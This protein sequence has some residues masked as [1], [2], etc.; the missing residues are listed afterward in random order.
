MNSNG[1]VDITD[2]SSLMIDEYNPSGVGSILVPIPNGQ[3]LFFYEIQSLVAKTY[4]NYPK[5]IAEGIDNNRLLILTSVL[6]KI[7]KITMSLIDQPT[8]QKF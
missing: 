6:N 7:A 5:K 4:S 3:R 1:F 8:M 2:P